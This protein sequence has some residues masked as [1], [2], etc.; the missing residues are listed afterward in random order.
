M[1]A[2]TD[3]EMFEAGLVAL[4]SCI[5][6]PVLELLTALHDEHGWSCTAHSEGQRCCMDVLTGAEE[7]TQ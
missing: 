6:P 4:R 7:T 5:A 3:S 1:S 2:L